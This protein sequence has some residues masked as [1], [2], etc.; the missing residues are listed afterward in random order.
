VDKGRGERLRF[1]NG[2]S[3]EG[4]RV[5]GLLEAAHVAGGL[6][7]HMPTICGVVQARAGDRCVWLGGVYD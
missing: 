5:T 3:G 6:R 1:T 4:I 2:H 7:W